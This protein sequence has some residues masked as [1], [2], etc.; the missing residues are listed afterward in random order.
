MVVYG[1]DTAQADQ[2]WWINLVVHHQYQ[3]DQLHLQHGGGGGGGPA[4]GPNFMP[5]VTGGSAGGSSPILD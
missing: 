4:S 1:A 3:L 5:V 2:R